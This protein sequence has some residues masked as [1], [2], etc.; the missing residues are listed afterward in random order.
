MLLLCQNLETHILS[1]CWVDDF[2]WYFAFETSLSVFSCCYRRAGNLVMLL[3]NAP[4][5]LCGKDCSHQIGLFVLYTQLLFPT[6]LTVC[7]L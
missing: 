1:R 4:F 6:S 7:P 2:L 5:S 3:E